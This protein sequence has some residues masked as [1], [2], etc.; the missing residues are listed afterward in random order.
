MS[1]PSSHGSIE[2]MLPETVLSAIDSRKSASTSKHH[3]FSHIAVIHRR[4]R[5]MA[6]ASNTV[7]SRSRGCGFSD[8]TI[9]AERAVIKKLGDNTMLKDAVLVVVRIKKDGTFGNSE[10]CHAC[11]KHLTKC[12]IEFGLRHVHYSA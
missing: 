3:S 1:S 4:G 8:Y 7:G 10:P 2:R 5:V 9:H 6:I 11:K 12:M